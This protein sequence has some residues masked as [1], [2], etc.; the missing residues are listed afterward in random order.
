MQITK[1]EYN[2][3]LLKKWKAEVLETGEIEKMLNEYLDR[4][5]SV[6]GNVTRAKNFSVYIRGLVTLLP[7]KTSTKSTHDL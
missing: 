6:W 3:D 4:F 7:P 1:A 2:P 5:N